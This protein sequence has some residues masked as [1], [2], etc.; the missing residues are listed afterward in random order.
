MTLMREGGV[1]IFSHELNSIVLGLSIFTVTGDA[2]ARA[3]QTLA[4]RAVPLW[5]SQVGPQVLRA[6]DLDDWE[7]DVV[8]A[9]DLVLLFSGV[10]RFDR[11]NVQA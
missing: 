11:S 6:Q 5:I 10:V 3:A 4:H 2:L 1:A 9:G 8:D 7:D